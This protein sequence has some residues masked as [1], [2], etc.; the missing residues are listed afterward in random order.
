MHLRLLIY[1]KPGNVSAYF[2]FSLS[3]SCAFLNWKSQEA[4][5]AFPGLEPTHIAEH[6]SG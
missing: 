2:L 4:S 3:Q 6:P 5:V 1:Y